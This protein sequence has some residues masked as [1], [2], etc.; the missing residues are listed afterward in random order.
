M[1][2]LLQYV[3]RIIFRVKGIR[4]QPIRPAK[5]R[6]NLILHGRARRQVAVHMDELDNF[7]PIRYE[8]TREFERLAELI[9]VMIVTMRDHVKSS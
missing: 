9:N 6:L 4:K 3:K 7:Q 8:Q 2:Q 5:A 1:P